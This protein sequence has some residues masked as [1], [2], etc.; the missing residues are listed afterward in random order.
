MSFMQNAPLFYRLIAV[1]CAVFAGLICAVVFT[2][3]QPAINQTAQ[4][5]DAQQNE[6]Q[7][8]SPSRRLRNVQ[9]EFLDEIKPLIQEKCGDCHWGD[10]SEGEINFKPFETLDDLLVASEKWKKVISVVIDEEMP[11]EDQPQFSTQE[12]QSMLDWIDR[13]FG[14][15]DCTNI[16]PGRVTLRRLN[17]T[18]Y[19][20]TIRDLAGVDHQPAADFPGDDVGFGF[21][22]VADVLSLPP[23]LMEKYLSAAEEITELAIADWENPN[24]RR[25]FSST[26]MT[27]PRGAHANSHGGVVL[28]TRGSLKQTIEISESGE[29][30]IGVEVSADQGGDEKAILVI[31]ADSEETVNAGE[32]SDENEENEHGNKVEIEVGVDRPDFEVIERK[33]TLEPG[34]T[35]LSVSFI[36]DFHEPENDIDRNLHVGRVWIEGPIDIPES[37]HRIIFFEADGDTT[38]QKAAAEKV[39]GR[40]AS[41][42]FRRPATAREVTRLMSLYQ[43]ARDEGD[44]FEAAI[45]YPLQAILVSPHF[46]YKIETPGDGETIRELNSFE[47]AT[48]TSYF[49]WSTMPDGELFG[50]A[51]DNRLKGAGPEEDAESS[52]YRQQVTRMLKSE[53]FSA[54]VE[55]FFEQWFQLRALPDFEPDPDL[56]PGVDRRLRGFMARETMLLAADIVERD[57]SILELLTADYTFVNEPLARHYRFDLAEITEAESGEAGSGGKFVRI[58]TDTQRAA[59]VLSHASILTLTSNPNRT[60]PVKRG[61]WIQENLLGEE[62]TFPDPDIMPLDDQTELTGTLRQRMEQHRT[63]PSCASCH[64][65]MDALGFSLENF[66]AVGRW[67]DQDD[68]L[69]VD[70]SAELPDGTRFNGPQ[71]LRNIITDKMKQK[72]VRCFAEKLL[73]YATGRGLEYYDECA[74]DEIIEYARAR[75]FRFSA[76]VIAVTESEPFRKRR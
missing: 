65:T 38:Q 29:Y 47:L 16:N 43:S 30:R 34:T 71:G 6:Q 11:P 12:K 25:A 2:L 66:D 8:A 3:S 33:F 70:A 76:F 72:F 13:L 74:V 56:F 10:G 48:A 28:T 39:V 61:K 20:N 17:R 75:D 67:R 36:N 58:E 55:N 15:V 4:Q 44:S 64:E 26:T 45:R 60:S 19:R 24:L 50:A 37:H 42:A 32:E 53:K 52:L 68:G 59:G 18:E 35:E 23:V 40:F 57:A 5:G 14:T 27:Q 1:S 7:P 31:R 73:I 63:N 41:R 49:L 69:P 54:L 9:R 46:L 51:F 21:D 22:N 62:P